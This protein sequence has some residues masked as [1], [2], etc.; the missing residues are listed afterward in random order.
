MRSRHTPKS[1]KNPLAVHRPPTSIL[2]SK[3]ITSK[4][5]RVQAIMVATFV[6]KTATMRPQVV[7]A[8]ALPRN[9]LCRVP[10]HRARARARCQCYL[11]V[12]LQNLAILARRE[13][14]P[15]WTLIRAGSRVR[16]ASQEVR[17]LLANPSN[18]S[19][20]RL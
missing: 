4:I 18:L 2:A 14:W 3:S 13:R 20:C 8:V 7:D 17:V 10:T 5:S 12:S 6:S 9:K 11:E 15:T 19:T 1:L 16:R